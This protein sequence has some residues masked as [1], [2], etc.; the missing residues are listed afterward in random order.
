MRIIFWFW[1]NQNV[2][3]VYYINCRENPFLSSLKECPVEGI[4]F[5][6]VRMGFENIPPDKCM[7]ILPKKL[8]EK[9]GIHI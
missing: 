7:K 2:S 4:N 8:S 6:G 9:I 1:V 5:R 3:Q